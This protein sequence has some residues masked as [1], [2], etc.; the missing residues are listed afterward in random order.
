MPP[1]ETAQQAAAPRSTKRASETGATVQNANAGE[2]V[3]AARGYRSG[4]TERGPEGVRLERVG[5]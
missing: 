1:E 3:E 4:S 5:G 2:W